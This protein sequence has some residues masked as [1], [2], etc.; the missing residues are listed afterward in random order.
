LTSAVGGKNR[1]DCRLCEQ[2]DPG[3]NA[4]TKRQQGCRK[5]GLSHIAMRPI[6][7]DCTG[8]N[9][10]DFSLF[11][12]GSLRDTSIQEQIYRAIEIENQGGFDKSYHAKLY[13][14][15]W[16]VLSFYRASLQ[17]RDRFEHEML[18]TKRE[19]FGGE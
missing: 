15:P 5:N 14:L 13:H 19:L 9:S 1:F 6:R 3:P 18:R 11:C 12:P 2:R 16:R 4:E 7:I 8:N 17:A 10:R